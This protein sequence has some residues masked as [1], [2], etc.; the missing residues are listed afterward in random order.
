MFGESS[1]GP[2]GCF[3][4]EYSI[5]DTFAPFGPIL[6]NSGWGPWAPAGL[7][8]RMLPLSWHGLVTAADHAGSPGNRKEEGPSALSWQPGSC[9]C[10]SPVHLTLPRGSNSPQSKGDCRDQT[11][12]WYSRLGPWKWKPEDA[13]PAS[14]EQWLDSC[15]I[16]A[17]LCRS[18]GSAWGK[19]TVF[20]SN[21]AGTSSTYWLSS[22]T[23]RNSSQGDTTEGKGH[24]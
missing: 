20:H 13:W 3:Q 14:R 23:A 11:T 17:R 8:G 6:G 15:L 1:G 7:S 19:Q 21:R 12:T 24:M 9:P 4:L 16:S 10:P 2:L 5:A 18:R 22:F